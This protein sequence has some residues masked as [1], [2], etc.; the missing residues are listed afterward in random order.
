MHNYASV[1]MDYVHPA[2]KKHLSE[3]DSH[4]L[5]PPKKKQPPMCLE[6]TT[7]QRKKKPCKMWLQK[8]KCCR[9]QCDWVHPDRSQIK[10]KF[11]TKC[12]LH[13]HCPFQHK[14]VQEPQHS[15]EDQE[16]RGDQQGTGEHGGTGEK[17]AESQETQSTKTK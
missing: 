10:C 16:D 12:K 2:I 17:K 3:S 1:G 4:G 13:P 11:G 14:E 8:G 9:H 5:E 6:Q 15:Q 7:R